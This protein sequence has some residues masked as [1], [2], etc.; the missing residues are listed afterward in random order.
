MDDLQDLK[1]RVEAACDRLQN[2]ADEDRRQ[3]TRLNEIAAI[4]EGALAG[5]KADIDRLRGQLIEAE[6]EGRNL[7]AENDAARKALLQAREIANSLQARI[8]QRDGQNEILRRLLMELLRAIEADGRPALADALQRIETGARSLLEQDRRE[9]AIALVPAGPEPMADFQRASASRDNASIQKFEVRVVAGTGAAA[10][11]EAEAG[12]ADPLSRNADTEPELGNEPSPAAGD[13]E[14]Q[15]SAGEPDEEPHRP[16][17]REI[18]G[19]A[20]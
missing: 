17:L 9:T 5:H 6:A 20:P 18:A 8:N 12:S 19:G 15:V 11:S 3:G 7:R 10:S 1:S 16:L 14:I 4:V 2:A 13:L